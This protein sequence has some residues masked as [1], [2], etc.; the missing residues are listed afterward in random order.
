M[1]DLCSPSWNNNLSIGSPQ[2]TTIDEI[3]NSSM[4]VKIRESVLDGSYRYCNDQVCWRLLSKSLYKNENITDRTW[5]TIID[6]HKT[7]LEGGP[8]FLNIGYN[9]N[10]N[11]HC[12]MCREKP[13]L[14]TDRS[15]IEKAYRRLMEYDFSNVEKLTI[16]GGGEIFIN[17]DYMEIVAKTKDLF[18]NLKEV[19]LYSNGML[20]DEKNWVR[21]A[22]LGKNYELKIFI[23]LDAATKETYLK[24][25]RGSNWERVMDNLKMLSEKRRS[26][27]YNQLIF[28]FCVQRDNYMEMPQFVRMA[29]EIGADAVHFE[30]LFHAP[31]ELCVHQSEH[32]EHQGFRAALYD[33]VAC[34]TELGIEVQSV[35]FSDLLN[36]SEEG[37]YDKYFAPKYRR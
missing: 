24:I 37:A 1:V 22:P 28:A 36:E 2:E 8:R 12:L 32:P 25:R 13:V 9:Q 7:K 31:A 19:W 35:P 23:S 20:F 14:N 11:L 3:W 6:K 5:R 27:K 26:K 29:K 34:G 4:A 21:V 17:D 16:P 30:R 18:P 10:C 15:S 33:A